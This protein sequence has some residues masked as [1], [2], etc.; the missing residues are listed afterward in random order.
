[1]FQ[2]P[3]GNHFGNKNQ[4]KMSS[5]YSS[6]AQDNQLG[7]IIQF[8]MSNEY[9]AKLNLVPLLTEID[10][11]YPQSFKYD[12]GSKRNWVMITIID[13]PYEYVT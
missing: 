7:E 8:W 4:D 13:N 9:Q 6:E 5:S 3:N 10:E 2:Q 11:Q 1:M 12:L